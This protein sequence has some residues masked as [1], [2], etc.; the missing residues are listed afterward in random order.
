MTMSVEIWKP[1]S[2]FEG[3]YEVSNLG[4]VKSYHKDKNGHLMKFTKGTWGYQLVGLHKD[5]KRKTVAVHRLVAEAFI[6]KIENKEVINH[7]DCDK[8]NNYVNNL[9]WTSQRENVQHSVKLGHYENSGAENKPVLQIEIHG[10]FQNRFR[11]ICEAARITGIPQ[12]N[13][14]KCCNGKLESAGGYKWQFL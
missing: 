13:I 4:R 5:G 8:T 2:G 9:E 7:I 11:S 12:Q 6:P 10:Y 14:S 1:I 3:L